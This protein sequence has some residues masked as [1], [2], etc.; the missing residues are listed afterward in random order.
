MNST[1]AFHVTLVDNI[2]SIL[3]RGLEPRIGERSAQIGEKVPRV[4]L[5]PSRG[6]C[7]DA[8]M[9]WL[10]DHLEDEGELAIL[11]AD[12]SALD[13]KIDDCAWYEVTAVDTI[14]PD[15][16]I[17]IMTEAFEESAIVTPFEL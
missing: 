9:G 10:G 8:L 5:F 14:S 1:T 13:L 12:V 2:P 3:E 11:E 15:R 4:Y 6:Y 17:R 16:I 7:E